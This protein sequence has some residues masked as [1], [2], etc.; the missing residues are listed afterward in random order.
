[1]RA[2]RSEKRSRKENLVSRGNLC[3]L[4]VIIILISSAV[5]A[6]SA[7]QISVLPPSQTVSPGEN[8]TVNIYVDPEGNRTYCA[9]FALSFNTSLLNATSINPGSFFDGFN[10]WAHHE[11]NN[12]TGWVSYGETIL[13]DGWVT[14][15]NTLAT[16]S[17]QPVAD[18][19]LSE[20]NFTRIILSNPDFERISTTASNGSVRIGLCGDVNEDKSVNMLDVIDLLYY[21]SYPG[22]YTIGSAWAADVNCD[23]RIDMLDVIDLLYYV[24][25][26]GEYELGCCEG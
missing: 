23:T 5:S 15:P 16:I 6:V 4:V 25:Y 24:S 8:F 17:F 19:G 22:E 10:T 2:G 20:L 11:I 21:V 26:P 18:H 13:G 7:A 1:M 9:E 12:S 14:E 3:N